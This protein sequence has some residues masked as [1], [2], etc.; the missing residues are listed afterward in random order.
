[1]L[2]VTTSEPEKKGEN[3]Q[4]QSSSVTTSELEEG[5]NKET[6]SSLENLSRPEER[7]EKV[8]ERVNRITQAC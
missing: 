5:E 3:E 7:E 4:T 6:Q 1:M 8:L 2:S